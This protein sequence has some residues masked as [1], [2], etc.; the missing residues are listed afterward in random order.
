MRILTAKN[1]IDL[2]SYEEMDY[3]YVFLIFFNR[4]KNSMD[5]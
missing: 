5:D 4:T 1:R 2:L 3:E